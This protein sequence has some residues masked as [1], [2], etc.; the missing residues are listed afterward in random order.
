MSTRI[1][2]IDPQ[3]PLKAPPIASPKRAADYVGLPTFPAF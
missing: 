1:N 3:R 2:A